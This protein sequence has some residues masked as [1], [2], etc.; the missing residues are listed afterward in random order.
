MAEGGGRR[1]HRLLYL[2]LPRAPVRG[3]QIAG[4]LRAGGRRASGTNYKQHGLEHP[5]W[6]GNRPGAGRNPP[7]RP[8]SRTRP[9]Q[10]GRLRRSANSPQKPPRKAGRSGTCAMPPVLAVMS[11]GLLRI[12]EARALTVDDVT[13]EEDGTGRLLIRASKT[14]QEGRRGGAVFGAAH[15]A[16][17]PQVARPPPR[18]PTAPC[19]AASGR[20]RTASA[21]PP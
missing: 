6:P 12:S 18:W 20:G 19:S 5:I 2:L 9:G 1:G 17:H 10:G 14:D 16:A 7:R 4:H 11:D 13:F 8:G 15:R 3:R 21:R